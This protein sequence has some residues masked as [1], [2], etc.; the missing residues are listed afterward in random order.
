M[1]AKKDMRVAGFIQLTVKISREDDGWVAVCE[2]LGVSTCDDSLDQILE[3][4][5]ALI[6]QHLN[7]LERNGVRAAF[8]KKHGIHIHR[9]VR[10][11]SSRR[12][13][14]PVRPGELVTRVTERL[15]VSARA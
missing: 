13:S 1:R 14:L 15:P 5:R 4:I 11:A 8:F 12:V 3:E 7:A 6:V 2:E 10:A 9:G